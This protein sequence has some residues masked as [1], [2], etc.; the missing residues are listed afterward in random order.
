MVQLLLLW[1]ITPITLRNR[2][3]NTINEAL[4]V[5]GGSCS[6]R[7]T[8]TPLVRLTSHIAYKYFMAGLENPLSFLT[9]VP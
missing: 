2:G 4:I 7:T 3:L 5:S 1:F 8:L 6:T 9:G